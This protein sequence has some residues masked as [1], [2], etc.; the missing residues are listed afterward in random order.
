ME[1]H[2]LGPDSAVIR[3]PIGCKDMIRQCE[4][5]SDTKTEMLGNTD[6]LDIRNF[7]YLYKFK[8]FMSSREK[9]NIILCQAHISSMLGLKS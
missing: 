8:K 4:L 7:L 5:E 1:R 9:D 3:F 6:L 2:C